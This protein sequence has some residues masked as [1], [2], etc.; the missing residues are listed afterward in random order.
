MKFGKK[1]SVKD[2]HL[3]NDR[4]GVGDMVTVVVN[5]KTDAE[6]KVF[7][8]SLQTLN[9]NKLNLKLYFIGRPFVKRFALC[10]LTV[11]CLSFLSVCLSCL[12][13]TVTLV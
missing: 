5:G 7:T 8:L 2:E 13:V 6:D 3:F 12:S 10:Y 11:V 4:F 1:Q 9:S